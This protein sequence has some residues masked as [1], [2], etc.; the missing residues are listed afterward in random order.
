VAAQSGVAQDIK[1]GQI[2]GGYPA[3][4]VRQWH[5]QTFTLA[6]LSKKED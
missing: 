1:D 6:K 3:I 2:M 5:R 4:S